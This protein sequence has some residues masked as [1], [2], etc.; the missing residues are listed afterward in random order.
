[1]QGGASG[2]RDAGEVGALGLTVDLRAWSGRGAWPVPARLSRGGCSPSYAPSSFVGVQVGSTLRE[3]GGRE[4]PG[5]VQNKGPGVYA[6]H[7]RG[8]ISL[9]VQPWVAV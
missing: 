5:R 7:V 2:V 9:S 8:G 3:S 1:M 4:G 6:L